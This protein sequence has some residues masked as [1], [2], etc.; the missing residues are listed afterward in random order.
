MSGHGIAGTVSGVEAA[1][2]CGDE[3]WFGVGM[4]VSER[5]QNLA[6]NTGRNGPGAHLE[7]SQRPHAQNAALSTLASPL[8]QRSLP[9][10]TVKPTLKQRRLQAVHR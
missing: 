1:I 10:A 8:N 7:S 4:E 3:L 2:H 5:D 9:L 6:I